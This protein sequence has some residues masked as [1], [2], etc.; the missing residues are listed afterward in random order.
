MRRYSDSYGNPYSDAS[1]KVTVSIDQ[2]ASGGD[3]STLQLTVL[4]DDGNAGP[5]ESG[6]ANCGAALKP[7]V[8]KVSFYKKAKLKKGSAKVG[9]ASCSTA[10]G[11]IK[12]IAK[13]NGKQVAYRKYKATGKNPYLT[14]KVTKTGRKIFKRQKSMK[15][16]VQVW[17]KPSGG[18]Q[19]K[20]SHSLKFI[21]G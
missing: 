6:N 8:K 18:K 20:K 16:K 12:V 7:Q 15:V 11:Q 9:K 4:P 21:R 1:K 5:V 14:M 10:C 3:V 17:V 19:V 2:P 13:K